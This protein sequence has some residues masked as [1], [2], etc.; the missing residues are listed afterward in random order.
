MPAAAAG[1]VL[2]L[3]AG[4]VDDGGDAV[5]ALAG[6]AAGQKAAVGDADQVDAAA[7]DLGVRGE[8]GIKHGIEVGD[9]VDGLAEEVAAG[10]ADV[11]K[12]GNWDVLNLF[13]LS[14]CAAKR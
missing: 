2:V 7:V 1:G 9:V 3:G 12:A 11:P 6:V 13:N 4:E 14:M 10:G 8:G 5:G